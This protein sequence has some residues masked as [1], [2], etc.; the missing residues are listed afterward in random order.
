[1]SF[2]ALLGYAQSLLVQLG[3]L[4]HV[5]Y[6]GD[7][8]RPEDQQGDRRGMACCPKIP[9]PASTV[10]PFATGSI[11]M[12]RAVFMPMIALKVPPRRMLTCTPPVG[13][14]VSVTS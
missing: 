10:V 7:N 8:Y 12:F 13:M 6:L 14:F 2:Q 9:T 4:C 3:L 1:M 5:P 11:L